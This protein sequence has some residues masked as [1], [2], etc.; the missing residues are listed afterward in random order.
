MGNRWSKSRLKVGFIVVPWL[1][2]VDL[3][4]F[5]RLNRK[6]GITSIFTPTA[7]R[8]AW[9]NYWF[10]ESDIRQARVADA[11]VYRERVSW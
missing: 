5:L 4:P 2:I 10:V 1:P 3:R 7:V 9:K 6:S 11:S 8:K